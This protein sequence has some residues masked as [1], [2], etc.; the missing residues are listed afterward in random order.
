MPAAL[1]V[2]PHGGP[3]RRAF[4]GGLEEA[5]YVEGQN[6]AIEY[7]WAEGHNDR[8]PALAADLAAGGQLLLGELNCTSCHQAEGAVVRKQAPVLDGVASRV[9]LGYL[10]KYLTDPHAVKPG[11][12]MPNLFADD[13]DKAAKVEALV[14]L[15]AA[16][17]TLRQERPDIKAALIGGASM[18][19]QIDQLKTKPQ[20][21][22]ATPG[23]LEDHMQSR[24]L[25][26][27]DFDVVVLDE[28]D[29]I[30]DMGFLPAVTRSGWA[31][32][33]NCLD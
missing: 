17:G 14:H 15:L 5:G 22:V 18:N 29:R 26:L 16:T 6:V 4:R 28:A 13:P 1:Q 8:L 19:K 11:S 2:C 12:T 32:F 7:R 24:R 9:R 20:F 30:L 3:Y 33:T 25:S 10:T 23:R 31:R 21:I 27:R